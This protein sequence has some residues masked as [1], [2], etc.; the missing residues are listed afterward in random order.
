MITLITAMSAFPASATPS[1][2]SLPLINDSLLASHNDYSPPTV[3]TVVEILKVWL[4]D[5][6]HAPSIHDIHSQKLQVVSVQID[7]VAGFL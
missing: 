4:K 6:S 5:Y 3:D 1:Y 7:R 2:G